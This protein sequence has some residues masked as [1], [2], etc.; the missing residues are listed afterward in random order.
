MRMFSKNRSLNKLY[1]GEYKIHVIP[2]LINLTLK[3]FFPVLTMCLNMHAKE[4][5]MAV[6]YI[7]TEEGSNLFTPLCFW[8]NVCVGSVEKAHVTVS[9]KHKHTPI[10]SLWLLPAMLVEFFFLVVRYCWCTTQP[11]PMC[12]QNVCIFKGTLYV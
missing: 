1:F 12:S 5:K 2:C 11:T 10:C 9:Y 7:V 6:A 3:I 8:I 4:N